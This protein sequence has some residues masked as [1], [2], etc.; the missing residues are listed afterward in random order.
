MIAICPVMMFL[1]SNTPRL[2][3]NLTEYSV[4]SGERGEE[5]GGE[6]GC[7]PSPTWYTVTISINHFL[8]TVNRWEKEN[9]DY[10][11]G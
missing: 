4:H 7:D 10:S 5:G 8:L 6:C 2:I 11:Q 3:L 1:I 9:N